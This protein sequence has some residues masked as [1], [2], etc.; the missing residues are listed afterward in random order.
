M[1]KSIFLPAALVLGGLSLGATPTAAIEGSETF[2]PAI[3]ALQ[4]VGQAEA[5]RVS[6]GD[7]V[8]ALAA[9]G[10]RGAGALKGCI[11]SEPGTWSGYDIWNAVTCPAGPA[12][13]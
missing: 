3:T 9:P 8:P 1:R 12:G 10:P 13:K 7:A 6:L 4:P 11:P 5:A 2:R